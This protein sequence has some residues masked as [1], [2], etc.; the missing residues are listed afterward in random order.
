MRS[1]VVRVLGEEKRKTKKIQLGE[2]VLSRAVVGGKERVGE[3]LHRGKTW[4]RE[5][6]GREREGGGVVPVNFSFLLGRPS[7]VD[8]RDVRGDR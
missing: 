2:Q 7:Q 1:K 4:P 6:E 3:E 5:K 8:S